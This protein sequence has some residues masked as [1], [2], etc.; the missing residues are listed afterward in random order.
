M[1]AEALKEWD[2]QG[3]PND[4]INDGL[5]GSEMEIVINC[6]KARLKI[7][8]ESGFALQQVLQ[9]TTAIMSNGLEIKE[10]KETK[11]TNFNAKR[12]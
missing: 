12:K 11:R 6:Q 10:A 9:L 1:N 8:A 2:E 7:T 4:F 5:A 3:C